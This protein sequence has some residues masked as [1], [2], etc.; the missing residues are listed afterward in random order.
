VWRE[1]FGSPLDSL[2]QQ[3]PLVPLRYSRA[4]AAWPAWSV[5]VLLRVSSGRPVRALLELAHERDPG[6]LVFGPDLARTSRRRFR[7]AAR[8]IR[9]DAGCLVW[10]APDG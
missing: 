8:L 1:V 5:M 2:V 9:R 10:I 7:R 6:L 4:F 3:R